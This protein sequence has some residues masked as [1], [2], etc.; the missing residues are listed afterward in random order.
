MDVGILLETRN[1]VK[2]YFQ[3]TRNNCPAW[4]AWESVIG[5][6]TESGLRHQEDSVTLLRGWEEKDFRQNGNPNIQILLLSSRP[7]CTVSKTIFR[8]HFLFKATA[9]VFEQQVGERAQANNLIRRNFQ[10]IPLFSQII[11]RIKFFHRII[12][13][14]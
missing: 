8:Q 10:I 7:Q 14:G 5:I 2:V 13:L 9:A 12:P 3:K 11:R 1:F 4:S 6:W